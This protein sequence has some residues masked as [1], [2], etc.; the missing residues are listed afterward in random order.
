MS[1]NNTPKPYKKHARPQSRDTR[2]GRSGGGP[3]R[4]RPDSKPA[5]KLSSSILARRCAAAAMKQIMTDQ[6]A[7]ESA[8]ERQDDYAGLEPRDRAFARVIVATT[9]RR[10]GQIKAALK[11]FIRKAP[12]EMVTAV[13]QTAAA[14]ILFLGTPPHAAVDETVSVLKSLRATQGFANMG[15]AVLRQ[16]VEKGPKIAA[17]VAPRD[18]IPGWIKGAWEKEYGRVE[19]RK[20]ATQL[21]KDPTLDIT[22]KSDAAGWAEKL[23]GKVIAPQT[24]RLPEIGNVTELD[25]FASGEWWVQDVA[26][27][28]PVQ[29]LATQMGD[30]SGKRVLD[31]CA[32]PGGKTLQLAAMGAVVTALDK[33]EGRLKRVHENLA[34]TKL[35]A[36]IVA[37]D[38]LEWDTEQTFDAVLLDAPCSATGT[39]RRHPDVL[40]NRTPKSVSQ[41]AR[42]QDKLLAKAATLV[43]PG[44]TL[45]FATCSLQPQESK[46]RLT[47]FLAELPDFRLIPVTNVAGLSLPE[48]RFEGGTV[49]TLPSDL[50]NEGGM[51]GFF[52]AVLSRA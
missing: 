5:V 4:D 45:V 49:R 17:M 27:T 40:L 34:R 26:A 13:L 25:G 14:Q 20:M 37:T 41:L 18:N 46:P 15:N 8:L 21:T 35:S 52:I 11:P 30:L 39:F 36:E 10:Q 23:G 33:S 24:V 29:L 42:L 31:L 43:K 19:L 47:R 16:I 9:C 38:A 48:S 1:D 50:P 22:V 7:L 12:P 28:L 3:R 32:A 2:G 51:D 44:G 6:E